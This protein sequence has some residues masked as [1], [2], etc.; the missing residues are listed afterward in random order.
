M[1]N[2]RSILTGLNTGL[3]SS[4]FI[5]TEKKLTIRILQF[6]YNFYLYIY[7]FRITSSS[8]GVVRKNLEKEV[9]EKSSK[10]TKEK[11]MNSS[12]G[13]S[14][15]N[16]VFCGKNFS[17]NSLLTIHLRSHTGQKPYQCELCEKAFSQ[18]CHLNVHMR[19]HTGET[20]FSCQVCG[21][22]F[23]Q[24]STLKIHMGTHPGVT[25]FPL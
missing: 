3:N 22:A 7:I 10:F 12:S 18:K 14:K 25:P 21:K 4:L 24:N 9:K 2:L 1:V 5:L 20:P 13:K 15:F 6:I 17:K 8:D 23:S 11:K 19:K 16:C